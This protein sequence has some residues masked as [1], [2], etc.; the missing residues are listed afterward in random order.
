MEIHDCVP[1]LRILPQCQSLN[2]LHVMAAAGWNSHNRLIP[3]LSAGDRYLFCNANLA[4]KNDLVDDEVE[5]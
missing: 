3:P 1:S 4:R 2:P 5:R